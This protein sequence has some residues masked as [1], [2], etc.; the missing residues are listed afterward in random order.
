MERHA[1]YRST[2]LADRI[3]DLRAR[4]TSLADDD[5]APADVHAFELVEEPPHPSSE[6]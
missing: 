4:G 1:T 2:S 3:T 5:P 6:S